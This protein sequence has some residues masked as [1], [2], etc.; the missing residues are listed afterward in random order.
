MRAVEWCCCRTAWQERCLQKLRSLTSKEKETLQM[1]SICMVKRGSVKREYFCS[2]AKVWI[3]QDVGP[4]LSK[5]T[6]CPSRYHFSKLIRSMPSLGLCICA[7]T[8]AQHKS[9]LLPFNKFTEPH[10]NLWE[11]LVLHANIYQVKMD[12]F[13]QLLVLGFLCRETANCTCMLVWHRNSAFPREQNET[14]N[15]FC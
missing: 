10:K 14:T 3:L 8:L 13:P 6:Q 4:A 9:K 5:G 12:T 7:C 1:E 2:V 15:S 11:Y